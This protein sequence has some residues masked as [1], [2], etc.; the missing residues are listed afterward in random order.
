MATNVLI[1]ED[2]VAIRKILKRML[3]QVGLPVGEVYEAGDGAEALETLKTQTV[4][5]VLSDINM[6]VMDGI[7]LLTEL[8]SKSEFKQ[9]PVI[10]ITTEGGQAKVMEAIQLGASGY[11]RKPFTPEQIKETLSK[12]F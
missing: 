4:K 2:S 11:V 12:H 10:M 7:Q 8:K 3:G 1:V 9:I 5:L 6:P